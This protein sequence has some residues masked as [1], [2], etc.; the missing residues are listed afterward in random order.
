MRQMVLRT[1][2]CALFSATGLSLAQ[3]APRPA[4]DPARPAETPRSMQDRRSDF[5]MAHRYQKATDMMGKVVKNASDENLGKIEDIVVDAN[6]GR[7]LYGVLSFGGFMGMGDKLFAIPWESLDLPD[8][9]KSF[10]LNVSKERLKSAEG[11]DKRNWPNFADEAWATKTHKYYEQTPYWQASDANRTTDANSRPN[12]RDR[13]Y[14]HAT[15]WQKCSDLCGKDIHNLQNDDIG[16]ISDCL[17]DPD[18]GRILYGVLANTGK[19]YAI[20]WGAMT[21]SSDGKNFQINL[22]K[23]QLKNAPTLEGDTWPNVTS[24]RWATDTHR[25]YSVEPYWLDTAAVRHP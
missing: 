17:I 25:F 21:L 15:V 12:N 5:A 1:A 6:S 24:E 20:P 19:R 11:F 3:D 4:Q 16:R 22:S 13:W 10:V 8:H 7:I 18:G 23:E 14:Q 9:A 2:W